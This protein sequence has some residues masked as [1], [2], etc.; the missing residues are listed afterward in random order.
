MTLAGEARAERLSFR[1]LDKSLLYLNRSHI[2][3]IETNGHPTTL[4]TPDGDYELLDSL[5]SIEKRYPEYLLR[6]HQSYLINPEHVT[7][8]RRFEVQ[9]TGGAV[10]PIPEKKDT[11]VR[12]F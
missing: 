12:T 10:L 3:Y 5:S 9:L 6:S 2:L 1:G 11:A 7:Q 4:H 8:I